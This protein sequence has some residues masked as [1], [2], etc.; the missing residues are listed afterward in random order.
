MIALTLDPAIMTA[1]IEAA[2]AVAILA[3][4][5]FVVPWLRELRGKVK[6]E[7]IGKAVDVA[8]GMLDAAIVPAVAAAEQTVAKKL[9]AEQPV[10][11]LTREQAGTVL[12]D[13]VERVIAHYGSDRLDAIAAS[14]GIPRIE[15]AD[16]IRTRIEAGVWKMQNVRKL[17]APPMSA[18]FS[19]DPPRR[20]LPPDVVAGGMG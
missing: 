15:L 14:L 16:V 10:G 2:G 12:A 13:A 1:V 17:L 4:T 3:L 19:T 20:E 18:G 5:L 8:L 7:R 11:K 9:R 6:D